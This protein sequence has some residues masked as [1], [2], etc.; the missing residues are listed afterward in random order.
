MRQPWYTL[1]TVLLLIVFLSAG[2]AV[3]GNGKLSGAVKGPDG[4]AVAGANVVLEGTT[5][6]GSADINGNYV[7]LNV[8]P[9]TYRVRAASIGYAPQ[10]ITN[11]R[12]GS[13]QTVTLNFELQSEAVG[14]AEV[15]IQAERPIVDKTQTS[16]R[17][18]ITSED[19]AALPG[20]D[21]QSLISTSASTYKG[22]VRGG[23]VFET[24]TVID[25]I[26]VTDQYAAWFADVAGGS[27]AYG[28]Y[29]AVVR[30]R[31]AQSS[32]LVDLSRSSVEE[33]NLQTGGVGS[34]YNSASA[35][36]IT[37]NLKEGRGDWTLRV[38]GR[39]AAKGYQNLGP[40]AYA[41]DSV[42]FRI[43]DNYA[44]SAA[45][46]DRDK[47]ARFTYFKDKY[48]YNDKPSDVLL[49]LATGGS[50]TEDFGLYL[51]G[52]WYDSHGLLPNE[53][54][55]KLNASLKANYNLTPDMKLNAT[56]LMEDRGKLFGWKNTT[57]SDDFRY[58]LE[59][60]PTWTGANLVGSLRWTHVL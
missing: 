52:R 32:A 40:N 54:T 56:F 8:P 36:V 39:M 1:F 41:D 35:G 51:T 27:T 48:V 23:R 50:L 17:T 20:A 60:V 11:V 53:R 14:L 57:Y 10:V 59:G 55:R 18:R 37:Y 16:A 34:D 45:Q 25:G 49:E 24:K 33:A 22:F 31:E 7:V 43:R 47:A 28:T 5:L 44:R 2:I 30:T 46:A 29:N 4:S 12:V 19:F 15:V 21:L 9:G 38:D 3:A 13:D 58:F 42:Y 26:D 6:G